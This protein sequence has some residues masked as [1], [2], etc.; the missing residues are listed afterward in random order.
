[1]PVH[2]VIY[3]LNADY[4]RTDYGGLL[5][6]IKAEQ[7]WA[8]LAECV[9]AVETPA[10]ARGLYERLKPHLNTDDRLLVFRAGSE[11]FGQHA[12]KIVDWLAK[13]TASGPP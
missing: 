7:N 5:K 9:Y 12:K 13:K 11:Y 2:I 3:E 4:A 10:S 1:M 6:G 8:R